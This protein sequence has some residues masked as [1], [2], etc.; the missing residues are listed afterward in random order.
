MINHTKLVYTYN[1][2]IALRHN[3]KELKTKLDTYDH[4][5][6]VHTLS[7]LCYVSVSFVTQ[8][9]TLRQLLDHIKHQSSLRYNFHHFVKIKNK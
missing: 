7:N 2:S 3:T 5:A 1:R 8:T 9:P 4:C 6:R